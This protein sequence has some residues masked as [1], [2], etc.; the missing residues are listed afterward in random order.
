ME[1]TKDLIVFYSSVSE[2]TLRFVERLHLEEHGM[3]SLRIPVK[4][5]E[6]ELIVDRP[7]VLI[8]PTYGNGNPQKSL[9]PQVKRFLNNRTNRSLLRGVIASGNVNFG[10]AYGYAG[11][12]ISKK[13]HVPYLYRFE[14]MGLDVD[15]ANVLDGLERF[16]SDLHLDEQ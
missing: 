6:P 13:A 15:V 9:L 4:M 3:E 7:Y 1:N 12:L 10:D 5:S 16:W 8:V 11:D 2:N 14:L